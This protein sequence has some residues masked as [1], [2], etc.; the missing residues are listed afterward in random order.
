[1]G[2]LSAQMM[3]GAIRNGSWINVPEGITPSIVENIF[4]KIDCPAC[5]TG[6]RNKIPTP[7]GSGVQQLIPGWTLSYDYIGPINPPAYG[8]F[9]GIGVFV[10]LAT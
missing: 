6:K 3:A 8:G 2:H 7:S 9:T 5:A 10:C 4:N 1:M